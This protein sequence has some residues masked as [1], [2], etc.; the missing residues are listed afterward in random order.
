[1]ILNLDKNFKPFP[2]FEEIDFE[3]IDFPSGCEPYIRLRTKFLPERV[4]I[5]QRKKREK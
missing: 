1:M 2:S 4:L 5:T 3:I